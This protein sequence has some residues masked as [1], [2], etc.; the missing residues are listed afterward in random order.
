MYD[1][2]IEFWH[3]LITNKIKYNLEFILNTFIDLYDGEIKV[4][5]SLEYISQ[6]I[7]Y[8]IDCYMIYNFIV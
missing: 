5:D 8:E 3:S 6:F 7:D 4:E 1:C 2:V